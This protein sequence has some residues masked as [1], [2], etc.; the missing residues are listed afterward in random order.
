MK[1]FFKKKK[2][3]WTMVGIL[4]TII[5]FAI[6]V[7]NSPEGNIAELDA[8]G[9]LWRC[10][11]ALSFSLFLPLVSYLFFNK[12]TFWAVFIPMFIF[13]TLQIVLEF[14]FKYSIGTAGIIL[15]IVMGAF[16]IWGFIGAYNKNKHKINGTLPIKKKK[17]EDDDDKS[18]E[19]LETLIAEEDEKFKEEIKFIEKSFVLSAYG[20]IYQVIKNENKL[21]FHRVGN[22]FRGIKNE[23]YI[24]E[25]EDLEKLVEGKKDF[26]LNLDQI[27]D[28]KISLWGET[29]PRGVGKM[30]FIH[31]GQKYKYEIMLQRHMTSLKVS[32]AKQFKFKKLSQRKNWKTK[33]KQ[34]MSIKK[35]FIN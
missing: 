2:N 23:S 29:S 20:S 13:L 22:F 17:E 16:F 15:S 18:A 12:Q 33:K 3:I 11:S 26:I 34:Q 32:G 30:S 35:S 25:F 14:A 9:V 27:D 8:V 31:N 19:E 7:S 5:L 24:R 4:L 6:S 28:I 1:D 21:Y 10:V